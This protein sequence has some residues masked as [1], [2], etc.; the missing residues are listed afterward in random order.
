MFS[1]RTTAK[2]TKAQIEREIRRMGVLRKISSALRSEQLTGHLPIS[3][4]VCWS[5]CPRFS[6]YLCL[7]WMSAEA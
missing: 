5:S 2:L 4:L 1:Y 7:W 6:G 3:P